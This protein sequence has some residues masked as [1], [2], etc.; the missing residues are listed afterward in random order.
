MRG[1]LQLKEM[2]EQ[3]E[4]CY[5]LLSCDEEAALEDN[6]LPLSSVCC[7][8]SKGKCR[9]NSELF[10]DIF[11][12]KHFKSVAPK[13]IYFRGEREVISSVPSQKSSLLCDVLAR[14]TFSRDYAFPQEI[15]LFCRAFPCMFQNLISVSICLK[16]PRKISCSP[17]PVVPL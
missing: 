2:R 4:C 15:N 6:G 16:K 5:I 13:G 17:W 11:L 9:I 3:Q 7:C 14:K 1:E 12:Q 8:C 10:K